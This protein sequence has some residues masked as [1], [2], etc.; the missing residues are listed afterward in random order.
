MKDPVRIVKR[1]RLSEKASL[2]QEKNNAYVLQVESKATKI[3][4]KQAVGKMF[5]VTV[6]S[7][8]TCNYDGKERRKR[9]ADAGRGASWKKAVVKLK[10]GDSIDFV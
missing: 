6:V 10:E 1:I 7:V 3:D 9:R 8:N 5:D 2:S 4:I